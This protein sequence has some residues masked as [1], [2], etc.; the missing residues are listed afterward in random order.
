[1]AA[2]A[3][4]K[5]FSRIWVAVATMSLRECPSLEVTDAQRTTKAIAGVVGKRLTYGSADRQT[6][7]KAI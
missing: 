6:T 5:I 4:S 1:M 7:A 2:L 3:G